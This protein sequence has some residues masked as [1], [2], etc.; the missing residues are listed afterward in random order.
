MPNARQGGGSHRWRQRAR[1]DEARR[2]APHKIAQRRAAGDI[3][4]H[5][6]ETFGESALNYRQ[7]IAE[8]F[9]FRDPATARAV[10]ADRVY[11]VEISHGAVRIRSIAEFR[12]GADVAVHRINRFEGNELR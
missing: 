1:E 7:T 2:E 12:D 4:A 8:T 5:H 9:A 11:L 10:E 3:T 6:A